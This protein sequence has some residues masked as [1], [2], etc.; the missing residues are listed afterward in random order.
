MSIPALLIASG[1]ASLTEPPTGQGYVDLVMAI[2]FIC[3]ALSKSAV[4]IAVAANNFEDPIRLSFFGLSVLTWCAEHGLHSALCVTSR[5]LWLHVCL[6]YS[7]HCKRI[8]GVGL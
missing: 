7:N 8:Q 2:T 3:G 6:G 5:A 1:I 4:R